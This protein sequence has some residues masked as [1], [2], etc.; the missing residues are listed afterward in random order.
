MPAQGHERVDGLIE[1]AHGVMASL[2]ASRDQLLPSEAEIAANPSVRSG[3][4]TWD[5][6]TAFI[7]GH[8]AD[9]ADLTQ[10]KLWDADCFEVLAVLAEILAGLSTDDPIRTKRG[11]LLSERSRAFASIAVA[12]W[13]E[14]G[15]ASDRREYLVNL[16]KQAERLSS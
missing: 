9:H 12:M 13:T 14:P 16:A 11:D 2:L 7:R 6:A 3:A 5:E 15:F 10:P 1:E 8:V 4:G